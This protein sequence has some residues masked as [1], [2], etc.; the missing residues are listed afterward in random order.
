MRILYDGMIY[1]LQ[2]VGGINRYFDNLISRLPEKDIPCLTTYQSCNTILPV[3]RNLH[4][5]NYPRYKPG[6][7]CSALRPVFFRAV[8]QWQQPEIAHPTYYALLSGQSLSKA[9]RCPV[10]ITVYDMILEKFADQLD[11]TGR[12][13][14][15]KRKAVS[16]ADA[17]LCISENSKKDLLEWYNIPEERI[18]VTPLASELRLT[19]S[20]GSEAYPERRYFLYVGGR[21][22]YKNFDGLLKSFARISAKHADICLCVVGQ[23]FSEAEQLRIAELQLTDRIEHFG[24]A[25]DGQLARLYHQSIALVYPSLY[26][27]FGIPPLEAMCCGTPVIACNASS[28][29]EVVGDAGLLF[30]PKASDEL[31]ELLLLLIENESER[32]RRIMQGY[33]Q[34][35]YFSWDKTA[36][37]TVAVYQALAG[38]GCP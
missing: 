16:S 2:A 37:Q 9:Y 32:E 23:T 21:D 19:S 34:S 20:N 4:V 35:R 8:T 33:E 30:D 22:G 36:M 24:H 1:M 27:G 14:E 26:E 29:P 17:V 10:V 25:S 28:I 13:R 18:R 15:I 5:I 31:T 38:T 7:F 12:N 6:I 3:H 11:P